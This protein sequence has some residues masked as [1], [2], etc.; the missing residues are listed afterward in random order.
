MAYIKINAKDFYSNVR[1]FSGRVGIDKIAI[2][3]KD[4][5]YG[6]GIKEIS[7]LAIDAGIM[8]CF[9]KNIYEAEILTNQNWKSI[10]VLGG[11]AELG[12]K[13]PSNIH[14]SINDIYQ[15]S[16]LSSGTAVELKVD[17]GMQRNGVTPN[18]ICDALKLIEQNGLIL[19]G[20]FTHFSC[21]DEDSV[22]TLNQE[23]VFEKVCSIIKKTYLFGVRY[24]CSNTAATA[25]IDNSLYDICRIGIGLYGY[26]AVTKDSMMLKPIASLMAKK[27]STRKVNKGSQVGYGFKSFIVDNDSI[28]VS[29]YDAGYGDALIRVD[30]KK[31]FYIDNGKKIIG[32]VSMDS[33]AIEGDDEEI[34]IFNN[35]IQFANYKNTIIYELLTSLNPFIKR[36]I[37]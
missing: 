22:F 18:Q 25:V 15:I 6:H 30:E 20:V 19:R 3:L 4:N 16:N 36:V 23:R 11:E 31:E 5:A 10:L 12:K 13:Y 37:V 34:C 14:I 26:S 9:V 2:G 24:H 1:F 28:T 7:K 21:A 33:L 29:T 35:G 32:R 17:T 27:I 8:H